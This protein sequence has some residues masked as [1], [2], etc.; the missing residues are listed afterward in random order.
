MRR[1][2]PVRLGWKW[3]WALLR[4]MFY[5]EWQQIFKW[6]LMQTGGCALSRTERIGA[7][8]Q[9][10]FW[11]L[12]SPQLGKAYALVCTSAATWCE[13]SCSWM[14]WSSIFGNYTA[15]DLITCSPVWGLTSA[16][17]CT[18]LTFLVVFAKLIFLSNLPRS[19]D[20]MILWGHLVAIFLHNAATPP[21]GSMPHWPVRRQK[22]HMIGFSSIAGGEIM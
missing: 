2:F 13:L 15:A 12:K 20:E 10:K 11:H 19:C 4:A 7:G 6:N 3:G 1:A 14:W 9:Y 16:T 8:I 21:S 18:S 5:I 22:R 17:S